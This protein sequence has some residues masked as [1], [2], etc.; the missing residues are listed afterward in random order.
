L[1]EEI[2]VF[3]AFAGQ[4]VR[5][6][7]N[8]KSHALITSSDK[9]GDVKLWYIYTNPKDRK[10]GYAKRIIEALQ[11]QVRAIFTGYSNTVREGRNLVRG[12][13][14]KK[15]D[16]QLVWR[17]D[18]EQVQSCSQGG[19]EENQKAQ[20]GSSGVIDAVELQT[21]SEGGSTERNP[22]TESRSSETGSERS[23]EAESDSQKDSEKNREKNG[24]AG[25]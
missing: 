5:L 7:V 9:A 13:G 15:E 14:F 12:C 21:G 10:K 25:N 11:S 4:I 22:E 2:V 16:D 20:T 19:G 17:K 3:E 6:G 1:K 18:G 23:P 24:Q 8:G